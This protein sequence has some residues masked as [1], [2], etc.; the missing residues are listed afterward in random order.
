MTCVLMDDEEDDG[1]M[2]IQKDRMNHNQTTLFACFTDQA[3]RET[4][5]TAH[6]PVP[7]GDLSNAPLHVDGSDQ[8]KGPIDTTTAFREERSACV[9]VR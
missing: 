9:C 5:L 3:A 6:V 1:E 2:R 4:R 7:H 8:E